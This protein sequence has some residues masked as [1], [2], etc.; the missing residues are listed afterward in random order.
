[1]ADKRLLLEIK[2]I[3]KNP[4]NLQN[5]Q[6]IELSPLDPDDSIYK[7]T[8][9]IAKPTKTDS[10]YYYNGQ[11]ILDIEA[12]PTYPIKPPK[13]RFSHTTPINHP[14]I[15]I[16]TGEIC[17]DVLTSDSWSPAWNI[18]SLV[19]AILLLLDDPVPDS[20][21]NVDLANLYRHDLLAFESMVQYTMWKYLTFYEGIKEALGV[22]LGLVL[23]YE[24]SAEEEDEQTDIDLVIEEIEDGEEVDDKTVQRE[25]PAEIKPEENLKVVSETKN[26]NKQSNSQRDSAAG[27]EP[28]KAMVSSNELSTTVPITMP[29]TVRVPTTTLTNLNSKI[30]MADISESEINGKPIS[31]VSSSEVSSLS[32][33]SN[34][35]ATSESSSMAEASGDGSKREK[36]KGLKRRG[37]SKIKE[38]V[39]TKISHLVDEIRRQSSTKRQMK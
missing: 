29:T 28:Q 4:P 22:K 20:P 12:G 18:Q 15:N 36:R 38:R 34:I 39:L 31:G 6:I 9:R 21:L 32:G 24:C 19:G 26:E 7:W 37:V 13:I 1:M 30:P 3:S 35:T 23:N 27:S 16:D 25:I 2:Q 33:T 11:W 8:A 17:L 14:N 5:P 10:P